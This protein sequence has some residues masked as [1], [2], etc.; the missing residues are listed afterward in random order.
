MVK[1]VYRWIFVDEAQDLNA[2]QLALVR[3]SRAPGGRIVFVGDPAQAIYGFQGADPESM[4]RIEQE[5]RA[6]PLP[7]S[8][9]Y[10]CPQR[11]VALARR[12]V[13]AIQARPEAPEGQLDELHV[14]KALG[15]ME[16]GDLV[17]SRNLEP[18]LHLWSALGR[19]GR[20]AWIDAPEDK[21]NGIAD[22]LRRLEGTCPIA[23]LRTVLTEL[24]MNDDSAS[25]DGLS[26][27]EHASL[28]L[29]M[30]PGTPRSYEQV[31]ELIDAAFAERKGAVRLMSIHRAKGLEAR[32]VFLIR[33]DLLPSSRATLEW[34]R[35]QEENLLYVALTRSSESLF[36]CNGHLDT[37]RQAREAG[38][39]PLGT[40][41]SRLRADA[42][43]TQTPPPAPPRPAPTSMPAAVLGRHNFLGGRCTI[44]QEPEARIRTFGWKCR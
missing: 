40:G 26:K 22:L 19:M 13:P 35:I 17:L 25:G 23:E 36:L 18:L 3:A 30:I 11:H 2:L 10:R 8:I 5:L 4:R 24:S 37:E 20:P 41:F 12:I 43:R 15:R 28:L 7:L 39:G 16:P 31:H 38:H 21:T 14:T 1:P 42:R 6:T 29:T 27:A 9:S 44:C 33:L 32:R 34:E